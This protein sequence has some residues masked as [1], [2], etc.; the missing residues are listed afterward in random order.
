MSK[1]EFLHDLLNEEFLNLDVEKVA[2]YEPPNLETI[3]EMFEL[4]DVEHKGMIEGK[5][6]VS[7]L[8]QSECL[9]EANFN[10]LEFNKMKK[11]MP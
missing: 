5:D 10:L 9:K 3:A 4:L 1:E 2:S 11:N 7:L 8:E 6:L